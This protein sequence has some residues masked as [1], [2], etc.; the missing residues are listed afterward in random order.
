MISS[1]LFDP[2]CT[3]TER[4]CF[5]KGIYVCPHFYS[6]SLESVPRGGN[7]G[8]RLRYA[9]RD[10]EECPYNSL[11]SNSLDSI[12]RPYSLVLIRVYLDI[13]GVVHN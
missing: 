5:R 8:L 12:D 3:S 9:S 13:G 7:I 10:G 2:V 4:V 6:L 1:E 11:Y